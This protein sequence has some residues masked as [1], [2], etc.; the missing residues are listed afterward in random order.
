MHINC[1][2]D[3]T[4]LRTGVAGFL[5]FLIAPACLPGIK[6][7]PFVL[8]LEIHIPENHKIPKKIDAKHRRKDKVSI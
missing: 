2:T 5:G 4:Y 6:F 8:H 1:S 3:Y 7:P